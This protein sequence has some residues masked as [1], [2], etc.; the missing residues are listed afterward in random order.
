MRIYRLLLES[1][2]KGTYPQGTVLPSLRE[3]SQEYYSSPGTVRQALQKLQSEGVVKAHHGIGYYVEDPSVLN[4]NILILE[5]THQLHL[6]SN[7]LTELCSCIQEH[8]DSQIILEDIARYNDQPEKLY[9]R[10]LSV[11]DKCEAI[12]FNGEY[13]ALSNA[14]YIELQKHTKL[15]YYFNAK[16]PFLT[17]G[18]PGVSTDWNHGQYIGIHHLLD[19]GCRRIL[20][21]TGTVRRDGARAALRD[22]GSDAELIFVKSRDEFYERVQ[23]DTFDGVYCPQDIY[24]VNAVSILRKRGFQIPGDIAITGYYN[25]PW[26]EHPECPLTSVC[27]NEREMIRRVFG[28]FTGGVDRLPL[29]ELPSLQIR[30]STKDFKRKIK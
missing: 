27:I 26:S 25:T 20:I 22:S 8:T 2:R 15:F 30:E 16:A 5:Q 10:L 28:M 3:L 23:N 18:V 19:C 11:A 24:A 17:A 29:M 1:I 4:K 6:Y 12:F 9:R 13:A 14:D 7:F 21:Y